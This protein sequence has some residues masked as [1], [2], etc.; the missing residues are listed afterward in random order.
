MKEFVIAIDRIREVPGLVTVL[1]K[2]YILSA[3][4][5]RYFMLD[6]ACPHMG[7]QV[8]NARYSSGIAVAVDLV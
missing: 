2:K 5:G 3:E 1:G 8:E 4:N 7:G 6:T